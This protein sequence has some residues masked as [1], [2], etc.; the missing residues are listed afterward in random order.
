M[1]DLSPSTLNVRLS[2]VRKIVHE[3]CRNGVL[4]V[5]ETAKVTDVRMFASRKFAWRMG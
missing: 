4:G 3:V 5:E 2:A 1:D